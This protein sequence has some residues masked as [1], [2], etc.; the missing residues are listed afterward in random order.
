M[1]FRPVT[2]RWLLAPFLL[3]TLQAEPPAG[4]GYLLLYEDNFDGSAVDEA[5]WSYRTGRRTGGTLN[6]VNLKENVSV[7][8]GLLHIAV[9]Q[10]I[11]NGQLESTG[12]GLISKHQ[13]GYGYYETRSKPFM[14]GRGVHS[15]F[16]QA[17]GAKPNND[18]FEI[19]SYEIDS[20][21]HLG[22]NNL[23]L[24]IAPKG[25]PVP[26]VSR[27]NVPFT[28]Q[29]DGWFLDAYEYTPD[30]VIFYDNGKVVAT[31]DWQDLTA[32]QAVWL[33]GLN[34][35]GKVEGDKQPGE[36]VFDYFR[37]YARDYPGVNLL[38]NGGFEYNQDRID[39]A[40]P[41]AW[42]QH[43]TA[44]AALVVEGEA[45]LDRYKLRQGSAASAYD[46]RTEQALEFLMNGDYE[47]SA[48]VRSS[49]GQGLA[50][51]RVTGF[52]GN[53]IIAAIP[54]ASGWT[55]IAI[56]RIAV[57]SHGATIIVESRGEAGQWLEI[58]DIRF[59]K[60]PLPGQQ[61]RAPRPFELIGDPIWKL[62]QRQ[63][64]EFTGDE[65]FYFFDRSVGI[66]DSISAS[67]VMQA[68]SLVNASPLA[69]IPKTGR[70][71]WAVQLTRDGDVIFRIG[72][73]ADHHDVVAPRAYAAGK[74]ARITCVFD[75]GTASIYS[76]HRLLK[77]ESGIAHDTKDATAP[78]RLGAVG[79]TYQA[80]GDVIVR[81]AAAGPPERYSGSI[82]DLRI[83]NRAL[84]DAE[85]TG[86]DPRLP[87]VF[88]IGDSVSMGYTPALRQR[89]AGKANVLRPEANCGSTRIGLRDLDD[90]LGDTRWDVIHFNFG[91]HDLGYR[92]PDDQTPNAAGV[93][94]TPDNGGHQNVPVAEYERNLRRLVARLKKTGARLIFATTTPV[95]ATFH[96]YV[97]SAELPYNQAALR[98]MREEGVEVNDLWGFS[99]K[100]LDALQI[101]VNVH[102]TE[103]GSRVLAGQVAQ[104]IEA[105]LP[106]R[107]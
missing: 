51:I 4:K 31:A 36:T 16:W 100:Q 92:W 94:A 84:P 96:S 60:P 101:P 81:T 87:S 95:P 23:Y 71:G 78:G 83:Y 21:E 17:G 55:R 18:I 43:G 46:T 1:T 89:L 69:R 61:A 52:G 77:R 10:E 85:A 29:P 19:D 6:G 62:A 39:P 9:R 54:A 37:Y 20:R 28:F 33:T 105:V 90:W 14:A 93:Y 72:S 99:M 103:P 2:A 107:K 42:Q 86:I 63:P 74:P 102:F 26:W 47:L 34:G 44:G 57:S 80:V 15:S 3:L 38:P 106:R 35:A 70:S 22:C 30:G 53:D 68:K 12:G 8:G 32:Q 104:S 41:V 13:F 73:V 45:A 82:R 40:K 91:L 5:A 7:S 97:K 76:G 75:R 49:G 64:I 25:R 56:P 66:G 58:D 65:K 79:E 24:H 88:V 48:V 11:I 27:A 98:V 50:R 59:Q 67:F